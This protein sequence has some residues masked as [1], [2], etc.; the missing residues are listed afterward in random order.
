MESISNRL[1][2]LSKI[3]EPSIELS[4]EAVLED[5]EEVV[6]LSV[7]AVLEDAEEVDEVVVEETVVENAAVLER[8]KKKKRSKIFY[9][10]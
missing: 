7:E 10:K 2:R 6:E 5:A 1:S 3:E 4:V 8:L 9:L